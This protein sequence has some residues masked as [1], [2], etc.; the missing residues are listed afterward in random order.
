M[1]NRFQKDSGDEKKRPGY[2]YATLSKSIEIAEAIKDLGGVSKGTLAHK[3]GCAES[4]P[5]LIQNIASAKAFGL[6]HRPLFI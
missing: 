4:S 2:P 3:L 1:D 5:S 6:L